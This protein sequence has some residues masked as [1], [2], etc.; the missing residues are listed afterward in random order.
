[1]AWICKQKAQG[2]FWGASTGLFLALTWGH[3]HHNIIKYLKFSF[4]P[5]LT[6]LGIIMVRLQL[7]QGSILFWDYLFTGR[8]RGANELFANH[9]RMN[10]NLFLANIGSLVY[11]THNAAIT[12]ISSPANSQRRKSRHSILGRI[13]SGPTTTTSRI[14]NGFITPT[15]IPHRSSKRELKWPPKPPGTKSKD[16]AP[17]TAEKSYQDPSTSAGSSTKQEIVYALPRILCS[18]GR[19]STD[20]QINTNKYPSIIISSHFPIF[21]KIRQNIKYRGGL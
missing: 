13:Q 20:V 10:N 2:K 18:A 1:M 5:R 21:A 9:L 7:N 6:Q 11:E 16:T 17:S 12:S 14:R 3:Y 4:N 19:P 15:S 8:R